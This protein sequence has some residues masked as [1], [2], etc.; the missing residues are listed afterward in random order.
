MP[1]ASPIL[2]NV[3]RGSVFVAFVVCVAPASG[4]EAGDDRARD[5]VRRILSRY[6]VDCHNGDTTSGSLNLVGL[7]WSLDKRALRKRWERIY[8]RVHAG[9]MPPSKETLPAA[10]RKQLLAALASA[11]HEAERAQILAHGRGQMRRLTRREYEHN[12]RD[13]LKL[14]DLDVADRLPADR[15][16]H[17]FTKVAGLLDISH[18]QLAAYLD[19]AAAALREAVASGVKRPA[20][21]RQRFTGTD[22]FSA[23]STYGGREA[24]FFARKGKMVTIGGAEFNKMT[25]AQRRDPTLEV[26]LFRSAAWPFYAYPRGFLAATNGR[27][28]I[29][30]SAR[31]VRQL[32][33]FRLV[34]A[35]DPLPMSF[36]ARQPSGPDVSGDVRETGGWID[37][38]P[39]AKVFETTIRLKAGE[40]FE[41]SLL[42]LPVPFIRTDGGFYYDFPPPPPD[43]HRGAAIGW[44]E[45]SGPLAPEQWPPASHRVLFGDLPVRPPAK[46]SPLRVE[47]VSTQ[48]KKDAER[49]FRRFAQAAARRPLQEDAHAAFLQLIHDRLDQGE[50]FAEAMLKGYQAFLCSGHFLYLTEPS[51]LPSARVRAAAQ[52]EADRE[53][54]DSHAFASRLSHFLWSSRPDRALLAQAG[55]NRLH[56][57]QTLIEQ[58]ARMIADPRFERFVDDFTDQWLDLRQVRRDNPDV[59]LYPEYRK[60]DYLVASMERETR[61]LFTAMVRDNL[62]ITTVVDA[63]FAFINDRL[64]AHY[65]LP[66]QAGSAMR[67]VALPDDSPYGGLLT[68]ASVLKLTSNGTTTSPVVRG[69]WVMTKLLGQPPPP[70][71]KTVP[72]IAPDI[73]GATTIRELLRKHTASASCKACHARFDPVGFAL[74]NFDILGAWRDRYRGLERGEKITGIDRAGHPFAYYVGREVDPSGIL[75]SGERFADIRALKRILVA[76]PRQ[77]ARNLLE[78]L[79]LYATGTPVRFADRP[80]IERLLDRTKTNN[81][82]VGDLIRELIAGRLFAGLPPT[83]WQP[84]PPEAAP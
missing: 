35:Y 44:L 20:A 10:P 70:P 76:K 78:H 68:N 30:F 46:G 51:R 21:K 66:R 62:S 42:G 67:R 77:L 22:I 31:A 36:R 34:P 33:G 61:A 38:L 17:G 32:P 39:R 37:L 26:A 6:C 5:T 75:L 82:R 18:V 8:D 54:I 80:E 15:T 47:V 60:D 7:A 83:R 13:L 12:L 50:S 2:R 56:R 55:A 48:P 74:E 72:A 69:A 79:T 81:Y 57:R 40:T 14:P 19:A 73:R 63:N 71:P 53:A 64:A 4:A 58:V 49:L 84:G 43:G 28:R 41:Y 59:R 52:D 3:W 11:I 9:E 23:L 45:V 25:A 24:M 27:Y 1:F 65:G 29:R 16:A